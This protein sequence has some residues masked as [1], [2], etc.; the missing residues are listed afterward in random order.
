[1]RK[2]Y[3][4]FIAFAIVGL[5]MPIGFASESDLVVVT[6]G[7]TTQSNSEYKEIVN[8][9]FEETAH[10]DVANTNNKI[11]T[12]KNVNDLFSSFTNQ[13]FSKDQIFS[14]V[15]IDLNGD[16]DIKVTVDSSEITAVTKEMYESALK[17]AGITKGKIYVTSPVEAS[18]ETALSGILDSYE[19]ATNIEI[20]KNVKQAA[21]HEI[22]VQAE[23]VKDSNLTSDN[24]TNLV[25]TV[26]NKVIDENINDHAEIVKLINKNLNK[27]NLTMS[28][29]DIENIANTLEEVHSVQNDA[30]NYGNKLSNV[31]GGSVS[32]EFSLDNLQNLIN[33]F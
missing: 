1:M 11:I 30:K 23:I 2:I 3:I 21:N 13:S 33:S 12:A 29:N 28:N 9:Y 10:V 5:F 6:Y 16:E 27:T 24:L 19:S 18:G 17:S 22:Y 4:C 25:S 15:C 26:K 7:E 31:I 32:G 14:S 20:P 8:N